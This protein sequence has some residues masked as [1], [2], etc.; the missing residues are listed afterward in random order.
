[1]AQDVQRPLARR[2]W[3]WSVVAVVVLLAIAS[4]LGWL[5]WQ[6]YD[7]AAPRTFKS[8]L[9]FNLLNVA[10]IAIGGLVIGAL[11]GGIQ[12][13][14][15]KRERDMAKRLELLRRMRAAHVRIARAQRLLRADDNP[16]TYGKQML[17]LMAVARDLEE[18][19]EEVRVSG[20]LYKKR[21]RRSIIW[22][23]ALILIFLERLSTEYTHWC[24]AAGGLKGIPRDNRW[25][26][27]LVAVRQSGS[28]VRDPSDE[29]W[30]PTDVMPDD[31]ECGLTKSKGTMREY[32]YG[33]RKRLAAR[34]RLARS[35]RKGGS[36][37]VTASLAADVTLPTLN[38]TQ[39]TLGDFSAVLAN[40][41]GAAKTA[42]LA[43]LAPDSATFVASFTYLVPCSFEYLAPGSY[44]IELQ[45]PTGMSFTSSPPSP[46]T[47]AVSSGQKTPRAFT[48]TSAS[49][50]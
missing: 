2:W 29:G 28:P 32:A 15:A 25:V 36:V 48:I 16:G 42:P 40:S 9:G 37:S 10:V 17:A 24:N 13:M 4:G 7:S 30:A 33:T 35:L 31:Y 27:D 34:R 21:D 41:G 38:A 3:L 49:A 43:P 50:P 39:I 20:R 47:I 12:E 6:L 8:V 19:R 23:I 45:A 18:V 5:A 22:G 26:A 46:V 1:M 44:T 14:R 11:L